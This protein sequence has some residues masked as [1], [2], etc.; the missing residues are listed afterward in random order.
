MMPMRT[1]SKIA[2]RWRDWPTR[3]ADPDCSRPQLLHAIT[4]RSQGTCLGD[5]WFCCPDCFQNAAENKIL[6]LGIPSPRPPRVQNARIPLGLLLHSRG[7]LTREQLKQALESQ[8]A[9]GGNF[10]DAVQQ[11][12]FASAEQV[13]AAVAAQW[14]C[15][16]F[17]LGSQPLASQVRI[18]RQ[19]LMAYQML[20]VHY[21]EK[22]RVLLMGF[23]SSVP[24]QIVHTVEH[25]TGCTVQPCFI[26]RREYE[27]HLHAIS[28]SDRENEL[29]FEQSMNASEMALIIRNYV[30]QLGAAAA[31]IGRCQNMLWARVW[32]RKSDVDVLFR[33]RSD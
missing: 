2:S 27:Q 4:R 18:P 15:P 23:V 11:L 28:A 12:G 24:Y 10:G 16:V 30:V 25:I 33:L 32:G 14:A 6:E 19:L 21:S 22:G 3:C 1:I 20:P 26:T 31:R 9:T 7:I 13:T 8:R 17:P 29:I 5:S